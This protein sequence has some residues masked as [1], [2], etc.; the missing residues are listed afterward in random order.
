MGFLQPNRND[1]LFN[2]NTVLGLAGSTGAYSIART[3][4]NGYTGPLIRVRRSP[5][6]AELNIF[7]T[8]GELDTAALLTFVG[9]GNG[10]VTTIY[11]QSG[12]GPNLV[13]TQTAKQPVLVSTGNINIPGNKPGIYFDG[14][15]M[16]METTGSVSSSE[17]ITIYTAAGYQFPYPNQKRY[18]FDSDGSKN[19]GIFYGSN[20]MTLTVNANNLTT[21]LYPSQQTG[22]GFF[23]NGSSS[24]FRATAGMNV[25]SYEVSGTLPLYG[26]SGSKYFLFCDK[27]SAQRLSGF[28]SELI[29]Y[30]GDKYANR[31]NIEASLSSF[32][33][34]V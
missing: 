14:T 23:F 33:T 8:L 13:Q 12:N 7:A 21:S 9:A 2:E 3:I 20:G 24:K 25:W 28:F 18:F 16:H 15:N 34:L 17:A 29:I 26:F 1:I 5:D 30:S 31:A 10:W 4:G 6:N 22:M 27:N 19:V 32:Y 11:D